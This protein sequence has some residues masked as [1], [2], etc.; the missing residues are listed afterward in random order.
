MA[1]S[2]AQAMPASP[3]ASCRRVCRDTGW[4]PRRCHGD[5]SEHVQVAAD[6]RLPAAHEEGPARP[7]HDR[8][9]EQHLDPVRGLLADGVAQP[10]QVPAHLQRH[11]GQRQ[12][13]PDPEPARTSRSNP[14]CSRNGPG[15]GWRAG[16]PS[17]RRPDPSPVRRPLQDH[18]DDAPQHGRHGN[19]N[20]PPWEWRSTARLSVMAHLA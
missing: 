11:H 6:E 18:G 12:N 4:M 8:S 15:A 9:R 16:R 20:A 1:L 2:W 7:K 5:Q 19:D 17:C 3:A 10:C 13:K 14:A